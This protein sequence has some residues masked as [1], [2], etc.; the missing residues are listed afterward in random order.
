MINDI[1]RKV[2]LA[3]VVEESINASLKKLSFS[4]F[5]AVANVALFLVQTK[6]AFDQ[7]VRK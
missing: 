7:V 4:T 3:Y 6:S 5:S 1:A 2:A